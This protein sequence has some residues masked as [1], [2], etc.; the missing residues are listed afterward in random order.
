MTE[1]HPPRP[2]YSNECCRGAQ[3]P[4]LNSGFSAAT[5]RAQQNILDDIGQGGS[6]RSRRHRPIEPFARQTNPANRKLVA[7]REQLVEN[8]REHV[9]MNVSVDNDRAAIAER[10]EET[11]DLASQL[12]PKLTAQT[13]RVS[14]SDAVHPQLGKA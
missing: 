5:E 2:E 14:A 9:I 11:L 7:E 6:R 12:G 4:P 1:S 3:I 8:R 13:S 10:F